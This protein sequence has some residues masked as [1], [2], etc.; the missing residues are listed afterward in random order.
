MNAFENVAFA[1]HVVGA[2]PKE[3][4]KSVSGALSVVGLSNKAR[5]MPSEL[6]GGEQQRVALARAIVN[7]PDMLIADEPTGNVDPN[8]SYEIV[9]LLNEINRRGTTV[10]M[11][12]HEHQLVSDFGKRVIMIDKGRII[13]DNSDGGAI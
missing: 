13:A 2:S 9:E 4:R 5:C 3:I 10:I 7:R 8:M 6:S 1:M 12:T 11:V